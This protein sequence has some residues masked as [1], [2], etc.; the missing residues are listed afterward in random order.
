MELV[1][2]ILIA[3]LCTVSLFSA[4][5]LYKLAFPKKSAEL[6][7]Q[8]HAIIEDE[9]EKAKFELGAHNVSSRIGT[10]AKEAKAPTSLDKLR[11][12]RRRK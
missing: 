4:F 3:F 11:D 1:V 12:L 7:S 10:E 2:L 9:V 6:A 8:E 5:C